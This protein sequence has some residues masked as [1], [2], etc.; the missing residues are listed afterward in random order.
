MPPVILALIA[1]IA[2]GLSDYL[3]GLAS[4]RLHAIVVTLVAVLGA[5]AITLVAA[6]PTQ[7]ES[8]TTE[9][10]AW[11]AASGLGS[12]FGGVM[13]YRGL[14]RGRMAVVAPVSAL[15]AAVVPVIVGVVTGERPSAVAW[16]GVAIALPAIWL[17]SRP[18]EPDAAATPATGG[19]LE[20]DLVDGLLA[21]A[22][23][24]LLF[25][26]LGQAG[27][28]AGLWPVVAGETAAVMLLIVVAVAG[29]A[30]SSIPR[31]GADRS[32]LATATV[33]GLLGG[34]A[35]TSYFLATHDG[36]LSIVAVVASLY[37]AVTVVLAATLLREPI[38]RW[39]LLGLAAALG[40]IACIVVG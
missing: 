34:I 37:P 10:L 35:S 1:A 5:A 39:Q 15:G 28:A 19:L 9:A 32:T 26:G 11:G 27:E 31:V 6:I 24:A 14:A 25:I 3:A 33:A 40:A 30:T 4:K 20:S 36:L 7:A 13:L 8:I 17:V 18:A 23:F 21:G 38:G 16:L 2:F 22:G 29:L 12:A